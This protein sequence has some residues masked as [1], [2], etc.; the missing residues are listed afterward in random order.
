MLYPPKSEWTE[1]ELAEFDI[2]LKKNPEE[3][4]ISLC[5]SL[6]AEKLRGNLVVPADWSTPVAP[7]LFPISREYE[8]KSLL[9]LGQ[10]IRTKE[11]VLCLTPLIWQIEPLAHKITRELSVP[12][13]A[14]PPSNLVLA[15]A[16]I[17]RVGTGILIIEAR[18]WPEVRELLEHSSTKPQVILVI[19][20]SSKTLIETDFTSDLLVLHEIHLVPGVPLAYQDIKLAQRS[21]NQFY[22]NQDFIWEFSE[23]NNELARIHSREGSLLS[24]S[25][26]AINENFI[27]QENSEAFL[28][29]HE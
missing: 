11:M 8:W 7:A 23:E 6:P 17:E 5:D 1:L 19:H 14:V 12:I 24:F 27:P 13:A 22:L 4:L 10:E 18:L 25:N 3:T 28:L 15:R 20:S 26:M 21:P 16:Y 2:R 29:N 9:Q